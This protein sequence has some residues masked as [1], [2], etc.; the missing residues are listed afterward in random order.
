MQQLSAS[1]QEGST[2]RSMSADEAAIRRDLAAC[3]RLVALNGWDDLTATHISA[4]LP[5]TADA[6]LINP[7]GLLF[8]EITASS[9][10]KVNHAGEI[11][12]PTPDP[13]NPAGFVI[14]SAVHMARAD[15]GCVIHLHTRDGMAV[16]ALEEGLLPLT[17]QAILV[18]S[19]LAFHDYEGVATDLD[20]RAR[21]QRDLGEK[22]LMFLRNHG[23]LAVGRTVREAFRSIANLETACAA[24]VAALSMGRPLHFPDPQVAAEADRKFTRDMMAASAERNWPAL[25]RKLHR[26]SPG[27]AD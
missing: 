4:R 16:S 6:F 18:M 15:A 14:H 27:Y 17:Q 19:E 9:L 26:Q 13:I 1:R 3:Y 25:L 22:N 10:V 23:T 5:G 11:L 7:Y 21:L 12:E 24:Q 2:A 8:E 20:E